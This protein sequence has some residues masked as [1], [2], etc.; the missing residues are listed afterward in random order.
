MNSVFYNI[1]CANL[2]IQKTIFKMK[3]EVQSH[4]SL[5][6]FVGLCSTAILISCL[7]LLNLNIIWSLII[8][9]IPIFFLFRFNIASTPQQLEIE[10]TK[11]IS[12][13]LSKKIIY[14]SVIIITI[15]IIP[16]LILLTILLNR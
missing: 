8:S 12:S 11:F 1:V 3:F 7:V 4:K 13:P 16:I 5:N 6:V 9:F 14:C 10:Y 2:L 15:V